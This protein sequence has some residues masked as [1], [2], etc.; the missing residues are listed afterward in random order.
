[1]KSARSPHKDIFA[2]GSLAWGNVM[3]TLFNVELE[4]A[5]DPSHRPMPHYYLGHSTRTTC[6][7]TT[8]AKTYI[9]RGGSATPYSEPPKI[10]CL[11]AQQGKLPSQ[12]L[13]GL[14]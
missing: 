1:M 11:K 8:I 5:S 6:K 13:E 9:K 10:K 3:R 7:K 4:N 12:D 2:H 14:C